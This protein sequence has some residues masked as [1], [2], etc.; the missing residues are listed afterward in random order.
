MGKRRS[1]VGGL[2]LDAGALIALQRG[3]PRIRSLLR[4]ALDRG[5][6]LTLPATVLAQ[7]WRGGP[8]AAHISRLVKDREHVAVI[9]LDETEAYAVGEIASRTGQSDVVDI[10]VALCA[11]RVGD[12][13][14]TSDPADISAID[15]GLTVIAL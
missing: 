13:V 9:P 10:H 1:E 12:R 7:A 14:V 4:Q 3:D 6:R 5:L 11:R 8:R 2:T 15:P